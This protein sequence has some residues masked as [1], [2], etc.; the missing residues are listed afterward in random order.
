[1]VQGERRPIGPEIF[2][3]QMKG[4]NIVTGG[5]RRVGGKYTVGAH[6]VQGLV[7][8]STNLNFVTDTLEL[9]KG[10]MAFIEVHRAAGQSQLFDEFRSADSQND[11]LAQALLRVTSV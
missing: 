7:E 2:F 4:K 10:G 8:G 9:D 5:Y 3:H 11:F 6:L 1:M